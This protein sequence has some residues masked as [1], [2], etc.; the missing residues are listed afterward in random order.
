MSRSV[1]RVAITNLGLAL[2]AALSLLVSGFAPAAAA[3][4]IFAPGDPIVTGFSG[5]V[6]PTSPPS[7]TDPL[8]LTFINPDGKSVVIQKLHPDRP[9]AGQLIDTEEAFSAKASDVGQVFGVTIDDAPDSQG[10]AAPNIYVAATSAFGLNIVVPGSDGNP[11]RSKTGAADATCMPGQWGAA[12]SE[13]GHPGSIWKIDG[14]TGEVTLF[15]TIANTGAGI[16]NIVYDPATAQFFVADLD[17]GLIYRL[18][19]DGTIVDTYDHGVTGRPV[20]GLDPVADDGSAGDITDPAFN[21]EDP[22]TCGFTQP[23]RR[24]HGL[25]LHNGR[26]YYSVADAPQIWSVGLKADGSFGTPRW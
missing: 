26:L 9:G 19:S 10:A 22:S 21:T 23:E 1:L 25:A 3:D 12:G 20:Q 7:G 24:V 11:I 14:T 16:G 18:A 6:E 17:T 13:E 2:L 5:V 8:D 4:A 15:T